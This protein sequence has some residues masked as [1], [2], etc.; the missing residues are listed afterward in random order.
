MTIEV[1]FADGVLEEVR[2]IRYSDLR[3]TVQKK[4]E[5]LILHAYGLKVTQI[6]E[7]VGVTATTICN[8]LN[9]FDR[10]GLDGLENPPEAPRKS[11]VVPHREVI[12][13]E[14]KNKPPAS[15]AEAA[16]RIEELTGVRR[17]K[18][19]IRLFLKELGM[20]YRKTA[21][22][23]AKADIAEQEEFKKKLSN[24]FSMKHELAKDACSS[25][26][27]PTSF[28]GP[29]KDIFGPSNGSS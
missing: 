9:E 3:I 28:M 1:Y 18:T 25:W 11:G 20:G 7:I 27:R 15:V 16:K 24:L 21:V 4:A 29:S 26:T 23:P 22:V 17:G 12:E 13:A 10:T 14:F 5:A 2:R 8:Y 19:Q 6:A